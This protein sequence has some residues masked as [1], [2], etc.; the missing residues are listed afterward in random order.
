MFGI[1]FAFTQPLLN[2]KG[3]LNFT[4]QNEDFPENGK[5]QGATGYQI[6]AEM[7]FGDRLYISPGV[8]YFQ[9]KSEINFLENSGIT[10]INLEF[11][12]MRI[13]VY[14]GLDLIDSETTGLRLYGGPNVSF[15]LNAEKNDLSN[16]FQVDPVRDVFWGLNFGVGID[17][18][19]FTLDVTR[20]WR[21]DGA[22]DSDEVDFN[23]DLLY[24]TAGVLF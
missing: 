10:D 7:R 18:H 16:F 8:Y 5:I 1:T 4:Q 11:N 3:G 21:I 20:E 13:P 2:V 15:L 19:I 9:H 22:F 23:N 14:L 12:G 24:L 6:G 17:L